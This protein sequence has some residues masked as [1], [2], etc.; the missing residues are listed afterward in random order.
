MA[1]IT[2]NFDHLSLNNGVEVD[3]SEV[4]GQGLFAIR[5][6]QVGEVVCTYGGQLIDENEAKYLPPHNM[7]NFENG[8]G[9]K[10]IG[11]DIMG[12]KGIYCNSVHPQQQYEANARFHLRSKK[13]LPDNR[14]VFNIV[15]ISQII[16]DAEVL[17]DYSEGYWQ[18]CANW[19][20][21]PR[22]K[23]ADVIAREKRLAK[24][25]GEAYE[26]PPQAP[27]PKNV[28]L[29]DEEEDESFESGEEEGGC[30]L[31]AVI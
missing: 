2:K 26:E 15:A 7:V 27:P 3:E 28:S 23:P 20:K 11:D 6:F 16:E 22:Y 19:D 13:Y 8:R 12:D 14:G 25:K 10:I 4:H 31:F 21:S 5:E 9:F 18:V 24:Y 29:I 30:P 1:R 17:V